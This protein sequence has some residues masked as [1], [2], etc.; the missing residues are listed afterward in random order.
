MRSGWRL[1]FVLKVYIHTYTCVNNSI[2]SEPNRLL[3]ERYKAIVVSF[4]VVDKHLICCL[5]VLNSCRFDCFVCYCFSCLW[6]LIRYV[7]S[8]CCFSSVCWKVFCYLILYEFLFD[9]VVCSIANAVNK[10][11]CAH[12]IS[13]LEWLN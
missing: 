12:Y 3:L 5:L 6:T 2:M 11:L 13:Q 1:A 4:V 9:F 8:C 7:P 10:L